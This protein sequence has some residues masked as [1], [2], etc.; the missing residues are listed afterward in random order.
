MP[1]SAETVSI[2]VHTFGGSGS[3]EVNITPGLDEGRLWPTTLL[4]VTETPAYT[5]MD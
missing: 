2:V 3:S 1:K 5:A 4:G